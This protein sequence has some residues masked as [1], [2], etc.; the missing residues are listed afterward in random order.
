MNKR[1]TILLVDDDQDQI[2]AMKLV[3]EKEYDIKT[4]DSGLGCIASVATVKPDLIVLDV[5]MDTLSDGLEAAKKLKEAV[6]TSHIPIIMVT[7]VNDHYDY[8]SQIHE[9]YFP[10]DKWLDKPVKPDVL[11][12]EVKALLDKAPLG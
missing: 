12:A 5:M 3:L 10:K 1:K 11:L 4:A 8:R 2:M 6:E 7:S 9:D